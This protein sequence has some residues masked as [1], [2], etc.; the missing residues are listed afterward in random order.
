MMAIADKLEASR[1]PTQIIWGDADVIF[2]MDASLKWFRKHLGGLQQIT[3]L[4]GGMLFVAEERPQQV[5]GIV[6]QFWKMNA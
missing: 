3:V 4:P 2:D 1:F 6:K 5:A